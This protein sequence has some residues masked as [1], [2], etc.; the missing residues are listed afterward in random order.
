MT[1]NKY[2]FASA[3]KNRYF[4]TE[5]D[6]Y[7]RKSAEEYE[8]LFKNFKALEKKLKNIGPAIEEYNNSK[9]TVFAAIVRAESYLESVTAQANESSAEIIKKASEEAENLLLTKKAEAEA[10]YFNLTHEADERIVQLNKEIELLEKRS[11]ELTQRYLND[12]KEKAKEIIDNAKTKAAEIVAAAYH[13]AKD[14]REKS[15]E[16]IAATTSELN[17]LKSEIAKYKNEIIN[18]VATIKPAVEAISDDAEFNFVP[19]TIEVDTDN[20][21]DDL[22]EFSLNPDDYDDE[23]VK[24]QYPDFYEDI[25]SVSSPEYYGES[26]ELSFPK[27]P[28]IPDFTEE[29]NHQTM[30]FQELGNAIFDTDDFESDEI[31]FSYQPDFDSLFNNDIPTDQE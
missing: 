3:G 20:L 26:E 5:V 11:E 23:P 12:T 25:S 30:I 9:N 21:V 15:E 8:R 24:N 10:Y 18:V 6:E 2:S 16:I 27:M 4:A 29:I 1:T 7:V 17:R 13:D 19:T 31:D 14:A 28:D 22:P